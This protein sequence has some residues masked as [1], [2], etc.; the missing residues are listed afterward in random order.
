MPHRTWSAQCKESSTARYKLT[1]E[2]FS[3]CF[4]VVSNNSILEVLIKAQ[5]KHVLLYQISIKNLCTSIFLW[6][7]E[8][9]SIDPNLL[10]PTK[11]AYIPWDLDQMLL[12]AK[13]ECGTFNY[14]AAE[15]RQ[16]ESTVYLSA[17]RR[18]CLRWPLTKT[19]PLSLRGM[20]FFLLTLHE[21]WK[22][23]DQTSTVTIH[24]KPCQATIS[25]NVLN[26]LLTRR[27]LLGVCTKHIRA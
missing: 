14:S 23:S 25:W 17:C 15:H 19:L 20:F 6:K 26:T 27:L 7:Y 4:K 8:D 11:N 12:L 21:K 13:E 22:V 3:T 1:C 9:C 18:L 24:L 2:W 5:D 16:T 10:M